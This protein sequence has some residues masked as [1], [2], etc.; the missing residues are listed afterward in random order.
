ALKTL[1]T[2]D[3]VAGLQALVGKPAGMGGAT[4]AM[5]LGMNLAPLAERAGPRA[6]KFAAMEAGHVAENVLLQATAL[7]L[8]SV[9]VGG[10]DEAKVT[11]LLKLPE[12][13][14]PVYILPL[15]TPKG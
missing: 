7:G 13:I 1:Q 6:E 15:G 11:G 8:A 10:F 9:P 2:D 3:L 4:T 5:V 14:R 12:G